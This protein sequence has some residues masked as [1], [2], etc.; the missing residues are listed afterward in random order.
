MQAIVDA[1][2]MNHIKRWCPGTMYQAYVMRTVS[3]SCKQ[4]PNRTQ[5]AAHRHVQSVKLCSECWTMSACEQQQRRHNVYH[6]QFE[7]EE[8]ASLGNQKQ[9]GLQQK[10]E[11]DRGKQRQQYGLRQPSRQPKFPRSLLRHHL[12][13]ASTTDGG[14][15]TVHF[16]IQAAGW[17]MLVLQLVQI[18]RFLSWQSGTCLVLHPD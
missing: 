3:H 15:D 13:M 7:P 14:G 2:H 11:R 17:S 8:R 9:D 5:P 1:R 6:F 10:V 16:S 18:L 4:I 12:H